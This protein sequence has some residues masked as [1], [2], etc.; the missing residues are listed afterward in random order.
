MYRIDS[1][2]RR[3]RAHGIFYYYDSFRQHKTSK[4]AWNHNDD[5]RFKVPS[6]SL[7]ENV[8]QLPCGDDVPRWCMR[9]L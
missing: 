7:P 4:T 3:L 5:D 1:D 2:L 9:V 8:K 6:F